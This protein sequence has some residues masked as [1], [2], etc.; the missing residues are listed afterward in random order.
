VSAHDTPHL[1]KKFRHPIGEGNFG[2]VY[3]V[4]ISPDGQF[5]AIGGWDI[6]YLSPGTGKN[7]VYIFSASTGALLKRT[8]DGS[9]DVIHHLAFSQDGRF[10][11]AGLNGG[12]GIQIWETGNWSL[13]PNNGHYEGHVYGATFDSSGRLYTVSYG[14]TDGFIRSFEYNNGQ[15]QQREVKTSKS[16]RFPYSIAINRPKRILAIGFA[17]VPYV[18][19]Y[20]ADTL[21]P[22]HTIQP[23]A[24]GTTDLISTGVTWSSDG[25]ELYATLSPKDDFG[26]K[27]L[28]AWNHTLGAHLFNTPLPIPPLGAATQLV[29]CDSKII[30]AANEGFG[31]FDSQ[32][33]Q[34]KWSERTKPVLTVDKGNLNNRLRISR[35]GFR[36]AFGL[37]HGG[38]D[39]FIFD[40]EQQTLTNASAAAL[41]DLFPADTQSLAISDWELSDNPKLNGDTLPLEDLERAMALAI[42]PTK[43]R[44][45]LG[46]E[47]R[48]RSYDLFRREQWCEDLACSHALPV[49]GAVVDL[50]VSQDGQL[51]ISAHS[52]GTIRWRRISDGHVLLSLFV[53][54][55][56]KRWI[57]WTPKGYFMASVGGENLVGW[58]VNNGFNQAADFFAIHAFRDHFLRPDIVNLALKL[59]D[60]DAALKK[61]NEGKTLQVPD[62]FTV[63]DMRP[64]TVEIIS[65]THD[66]LI[67]GDTLSITYRVRSPLYKVTRL[68]VMIDG[69]VFHRPFDPN[70]LNKELSLVVPYARGGE[71]LSLIAYSEERYSFH[72]ATVTLNSKKAE[73]YVPPLK[74]K[75]FGLTIGIKNYSSR[76]L[77]WA[78]LDAKHLS[79]VLN[80]QPHD[81]KPHGA[82][83]RL[84][85]D[86]SVKYLI[87]ENAD[88]KS[89]TSELAR[90]REAM[91]NEEAD[92]TKGRIQDIA[93]IFYAGH[94]EVADTG[95]FY[96]TPP[97][98]QT[99]DGKPSSLRDY[100]LSDQELI[101]EIR[102]MPGMKLLFID[103]CRAGS[104]LADLPN[105]NFAPVI[106][107]L[108]DVTVVFASS[109]P[110]ELSFECDEHG[111]FTEAL[112][113][114][115]RGKADTHYPSGV[116]STDEIESYL[117]SQV[118]Y[119]RKPK[120]DQRPIM[121]KSS[122]FPHFD[123]LLPTPDIRLSIQGN[124]AGGQK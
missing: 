21:T 45:I 59:R 116:I 64:P 69:S 62:T 31:I 103:A 20:D 74:P 19:V 37:E 4:A 91:R 96:F 88:K 5:V 55:L 1:V 71:T 98:P 40:V 52:D 86:V 12:Q 65:P 58:H 112:I 113:D 89:I 28:Y 23:P 41:H 10:L 123:F 102:A 34:L 14:A 16:G 27:T 118:L 111:C 18:D 80:S 115:L 47:W 44:F 13:I 76:P 54:R 107:N 75:L 17:D 117:I 9:D 77:L 3:A 51:V 110:K 78:D 8:D 87:N 79:E 66:S 46:T 61:A 93:V 83:Q 6:G 22:T 108:A 92:V 114:A 24:A 122:V 72:P 48:I 67:S 15:F 25:E 121:H 53:N 57:A 36:V 32:S 39:S 94:G 109:G 42:V 81:A 30:I 29:T 97:S 26:P 50:N 82:T 70:N 104:T 100:A 35:N 99:P 7:H 95:R 119:L 56:E 106:N 124:V 38:N 60:E 68:D 90:M 101:D 73:N 120:T 2:K 33:K 85:R 84:F 11:V 63:L 43:D 105:F 49:E